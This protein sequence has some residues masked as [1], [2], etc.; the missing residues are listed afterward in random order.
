M[1]VVTSGYLHKHTYN[2]YIMI[3]YYALQS[4]MASPTKSTEVPTSVCVPSRT[5]RGTSGA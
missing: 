2:I 4:F 5:P 1:W 3:L